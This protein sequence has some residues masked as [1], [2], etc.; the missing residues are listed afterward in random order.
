MKISFQ[1]PFC[2]P[3][4]GI[5]YVLILMLSI[6]LA[7]TGCGDTDAKNKHNII[8]RDGKI[9]FTLGD[10]KFVIPEGNFKGGTETGGGS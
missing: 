9:Y 7:L 6:A 8:K 10:R 3:N 5:A 2:I 4:S 1:W